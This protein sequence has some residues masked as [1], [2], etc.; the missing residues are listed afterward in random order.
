MGLVRRGSAEGLFCEGKEDGRRGK[1]LPRRST[2]RDTHEII[3]FKNCMSPSCHDRHT[4]TYSMYDT[5]VPSRQKNNVDL[6]NMRTPLAP[7]TAVFSFV[8]KIELHNKN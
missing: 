3:L 2:T 1:S 5:F 6:K 4:C 8:M 7:Y